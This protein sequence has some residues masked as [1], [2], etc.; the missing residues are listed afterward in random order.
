MAVS[1][2]L[3]V[4]Q[5]LWKTL[6]K[7]LTRYEHRDTWTSYRQAALPFLLRPCVANHFSALTTMHHVILGVPGCTFRSWDFGKLLCLKLANVFILY[8]VKRSVRASEK[9]CAAMDE[10]CVCPLNDM[11]YQFFF[12]LLTDIVVWLP[13]LCACCDEG[14][15]AGH[16]LDPK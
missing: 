6:V 7:K 1:V 16:N 5:L 15:A 10:L 4:S 12:L 8:V 9:E 14:T 3:G 11:G 13:Y 2:V